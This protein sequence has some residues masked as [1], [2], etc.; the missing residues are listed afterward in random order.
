MVTVEPGSSRGGTEV[1]YT[2]LPKWWGRGL[3]REV[4]AAAAEWARALPRDNPCGRDAEREHGVPARTGGRRPGD[5]RRSRRVRRA[6]S[7]C[8]DPSCDHQRY[9][10]GRG[11]KAAGEIIG[12]TDS[13]ARHGG[14]FKEPCGA[15]RPPRWEVKRRGTRS[16]TRWAAAASSSEE[17]VEV[18][19]QH[20][21]GAFM[22]VIVAGP[23]S[24]HRGRRHEKDPA[25]LLA[26]AAL[27]R[28]LTGALQHGADI[29]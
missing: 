2:L 17:E 27:E 10:A 13:G 20:L 8:I 23:H 19:P 5:E 12:R 16:P 24:G 3:G 25:V 6:G 22:P 21:T 28:R 9:M 14:S 1:S 7:R 4:V 18:H 15:A 11:G 26:V 29:Q